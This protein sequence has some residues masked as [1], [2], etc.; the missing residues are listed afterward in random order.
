MNVQFQLR[1]L[2]ISENNGVNDLMY[3]IIIIIIIKNKNV[4]Q[5]LEHRSILYTQSYKLTPKYPYFS[6]KILYIK[7]N[8]P[9]YIVY[10]KTPGRT[11]EPGI[12]MHLERKTSVSAYFFVG[13][14]FPS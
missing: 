3:L 1:L 9:M 13:S 11:A 2:H 8:K 4:P 5:I 7:V 14:D 12:T 10:P 6:V